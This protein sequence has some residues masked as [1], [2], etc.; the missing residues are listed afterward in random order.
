VSSTGRPRRQ[1]E[2]CHDGPRSLRWRSTIGVGLRHLLA[3]GV[4]S[5]QWSAG[6]LQRRSVSS[7]GRS[8]RQ[9]ER[10]HDGPRSLRRR[11]TI[12]VGLR[13]LLASGMGPWR[14]I[15]QEQVEGR[16]CWLDPVRRSSQTAD[17]ARRSPTATDPTS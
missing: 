14:W 5:W 8:R 2:R 10:C 15:R 12:G 13:H 7:I 17:P 3:S 16:G 9:C 11:S 6:S 1:C 4:G